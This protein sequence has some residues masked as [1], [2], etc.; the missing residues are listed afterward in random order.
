M[1]LVI[2]TNVGVVANLPSK[3]MP[4]SSVSLLCQQRCIMLLL[5]VTRGE[6]MLVLDDAWRIIHEY[7]RQLRSSGQPGVGD[8]FYKWVLTNHANPERCEC[9]PLHEE[10]DELGN[11]FWREFPQDDEAFVG[12]DPS[13]RKFVALSL[14]HGEKP[15]I[16]NA[17]DRDWRDYAKPLARYG[18]RVWFVCPEQM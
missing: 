13:D 10:K 7:G 4:D 8:A 18:V 1:K 14:A 6:H 12:F 16:C 2:D 5:A 17:T 9:V 3:E 11:T 15:E